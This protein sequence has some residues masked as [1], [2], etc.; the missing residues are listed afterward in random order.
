MSD[1][2][3]ALVRTAPPPNTDPRNSR[4]SNLRRD[5]VDVASPQT[6]RK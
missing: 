2:V 6:D 3:I 5:R 1:A 4:A